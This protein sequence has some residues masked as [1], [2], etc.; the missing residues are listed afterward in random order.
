[1]KNSRRAMLLV[2]NYGLPMEVCDYSKSNLF[3]MWHLLSIQ[4]L[5][6]GA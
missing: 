1:M 2:S 3:N 4:A 5:N 6:P